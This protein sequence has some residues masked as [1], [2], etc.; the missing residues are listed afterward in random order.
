[1]NLDQLDETVAEG[2]VPNC[3]CKDRSQGGTVVT[4]WVDGL[5][6]K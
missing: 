5:R 3:P 6:V 2:D 1:M 4:P